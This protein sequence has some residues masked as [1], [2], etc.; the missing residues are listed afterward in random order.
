MPCENWRR[1]TNR[2]DSRLL[3]LRHWR[4]TCGNRRSFAGIAGVLALA[5]RKNHA[6][7]RHWLWLVASVKFLIPFSLLA[8]RGRSNWIGMADRQ[9]RGA[10]GTAG[11][12]GTDQP[13]VSVLARQHRCGCR[14]GRGA[15]RQPA[16]GRFSRDMGVRFPGCGILLVAAM[17]AHPRRR[18]RRFAARASQRTC[19][20]CPR[21]PCWSRVFSASSVRCCCCRMASRSAWRPRTWRRSWRTNCATSGAATIWR[22]RSTW[23]WKRSSGFIPWCGG[24]ERAW[25][26]NANAPAT[27]KCC[28]SAA[29]RRYMPKAF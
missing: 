8:A 7:T 29:S 22:R 14:A 21:R 5:L 15:T 17:A 18:A 24:S 27:K 13:A 11:R 3:S 16:A 19:P 2:N 25:W 1:R 12:G 6:R 26:R 23:W 9:S 20:C 10:A 28:A 4:T